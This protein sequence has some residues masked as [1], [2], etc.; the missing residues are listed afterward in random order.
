MA[1][2]DVLSMI[3]DIEAEVP[4]VQ[5]TQVVTDLLAHVDAPLPEQPAVPK[6]KRPGRP[7]KRIEATPA[8]KFGI[9]PRPAHADHVLELVYSNPKLFTWIWSS[10]RAN[11]SQEIHWY[12]TTDKLYIYGRD[13]LGKISIYNSLDA[14]HFNLYHCA[15]PVHF[16]V[17][18]EAISILT[19]LITRTVYRITFSSTIQHV[20]QFITVQL[21]D[22]I[23]KRVTTRNVPVTWYSPTAHVA[24]I[25]PNFE[26][27]VKFKNNATSLKTLMNGWH[28][29]KI[30]SYSIEKI[31]GLPLTF[32]PTNSQTEQPS[33]FPDSEAIGL[34]TQI[35]P[36]E[37]FRVTV[38]IAHTRAF[39][40]TCVA[41]DVEIAID[42][43]RI[44]YSADFEKIT[45]DAGDVS[46]LA[47]L[48]VIANV[49]TIG[50]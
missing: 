33:T 34:V 15:Y 25:A 18:Y 26:P 20:N 5:P 41:T 28:K 32:V 17:T 44:Q 14:N 38:D 1:D 12:W 7:P 22:S 49:H 6:K 9:V 3:D 11:Q 10:F 4:T 16:A 45:S 30:K 40:A 43:S 36:G 8:R 13:R 39:A 23:D 37:H 19:E 29:Y 31:D 24:H 27:V 50:R 48:T 21:H 35:P 47:H 2:S 42:S 46:Y